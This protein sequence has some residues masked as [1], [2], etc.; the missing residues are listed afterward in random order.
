MI[1]DIFEIKYHRR[2]IYWLLERIGFKLVKP[3]P[4]HIKKNEKEV[5]RFYSQ[6]L[7][8]LQKKAKI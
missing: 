3:Y 5:E 8:A 1:A 4:I 2:H 6:V 7:P